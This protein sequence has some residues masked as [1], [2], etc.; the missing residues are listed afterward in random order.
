MPRS[1]SPADALF[2]Q[3]LPLADSIALG[4]HRKG[5]QL[6]E[7]DDCRQVAR[8]ALWLAASR[9]EDPISAPA[10][11]SRC[12]RGA[13]LHHA[14]DLGRAIRVPRREQ[15]KPGAKIPWQLESLDAQLSGGEAL[16]DLVADVAPEP[17]VDA[18]MLEGLLDQL[19]ARQAA[20]I[21]L[22]QLQGLSCRDAAQQ[23]GISRM[24]VC[25]DERQGLAQLRQQLAGGG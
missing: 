16:I 22:R 24:S 2:R 5:R 15:E 1:Q 13:L 9:I 11:L 7:L 6:I 19:P 10:Y 3:F 20:A 14:R 4:F 8:M 17:E 12:I 25:R 18:Q 23:L 21:R